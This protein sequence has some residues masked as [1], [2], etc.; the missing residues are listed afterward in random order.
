ML[1]SAFWERM[2]GEP[3]KLASPENPS[4]AEL[5]AEAHFNIDTKD[6]KSFEKS[7]RG[8]AFQKAILEHPDADAKLKKYV[9]NVGSYLK[10]KEVVAVVPSRSR[11]AKYKIK[12][13]PSGRM[14]CGCKDWQYVHSVNGTD[15]DHIKAVK[16]MKSKMS[17]AMQVARGVARMRRYHRNKNEGVKGNTME[18][19]VKRLRLDMPLLPVK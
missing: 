4:K 13:L 18:E 1:S 11:S 7:L 12:V 15:C 16:M 6:W 8:K 19:N 10:A 17:S 2:F 5:K 14:G 3:I 9:K